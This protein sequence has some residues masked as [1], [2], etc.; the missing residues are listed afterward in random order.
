MEGDKE[1]KSEKEGEVEERSQRRRTTEE[2]CPEVEWCKDEFWTPI[3]QPRE[4]GFQ[5]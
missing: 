3:L 5:L 2:A 1:V 4:P